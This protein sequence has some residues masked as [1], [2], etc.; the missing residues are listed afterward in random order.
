[1]KG[2][3]LCLLVVFAA[4]TR[5]APAAANPATEITA[6]GSGSV[7][8]PPD[9]ATINAVVVTQSE[10][11][12]DAVSRNN[13]RYE[14]VVAS[15]TQLGIARGDISLTYYNVSYNPRPAGTTTNAPGEI[16]GYTVNRSFA[17]KVRQIGNA[18]RVSDAALAA[19]ATSIDNVSFGIS[20]PHSARMEATRRAVAEARSNA[21]AVAGAAGLRI[22]GIKS[23]EFG[24]FAPAPM[25]AR[26][27]SAKMSAPT[28][29][30]QSNVNV[31]VSVSVV[32]FAEP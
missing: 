16:Y 7:A 21:E 6:P 26:V 17:V 25:I 8:L 30:D 31:T 28:E 22:T 4:L 14:R 15:L 3:F 10:N 19:G 18:G 11:A 20:N 5:V 32:F 29:F 24:G 13:A 2:T 27:S 12:Q 1:M 23:I 9:M